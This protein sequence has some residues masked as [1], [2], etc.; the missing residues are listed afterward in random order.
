ME[1]P[2]VKEIKTMIRQTGL[3]QLLRLVRQAIANRLVWEAGYYARQLAR[4]GI[5][6]A[7]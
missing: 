1:G 7:N 3:T 5:F 4:A 6:F 2:E